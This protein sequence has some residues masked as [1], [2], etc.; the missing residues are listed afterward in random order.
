MGQR[1][2]DDHLPLN[3]AG[4]PTI[5]I[6]DFEYGPGNGYWHTPDDIPANTSAET[7]RMVGEVVAELVYRQQ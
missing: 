4:I 3:D 7:L 6:I 2:L 5:D 1:V